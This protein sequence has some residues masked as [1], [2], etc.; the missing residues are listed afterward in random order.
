M[1]GIQR[2]DHSHCSA[3]GDLGV[4]AGLITEMR[5]CGC[6]ARNAWLLSGEC[7]L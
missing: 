2:W 1:I 4:T 5:I 3:M 6:V 7:C